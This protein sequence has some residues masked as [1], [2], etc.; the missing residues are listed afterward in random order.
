MHDWR[1]V[2]VEDDRVV[3]RLHC[4]FIAQVSGYSVAAVAASAAQAEEMVRVLRPDL[5]MLDIGLPGENG[6][7][8][9][10]R[11]RA[12]AED[13]EVI[14][15]TAA[16]ATATVHA[17]VQL[18]ALDY[19]VKPFD[20]DRLRKSLRL[21]E[22]RMSMLERAQ[23]AQRDVD[24]ICSEGPNVLRWLPRDVSGQRLDEIRG[25]LSG[26]RTGETAETVATQAGVARVTARRYLEYL[27]TIGQAT[28]EPVVDGPG[29]PRKT[30][31]LIYPGA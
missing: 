15:V 30:Y 11:L 5:L 13:V 27:V 29:R 22:R 16:T 9:L 31:Q 10:R 14:A 4:R 7:V 19:L 20:Q 6:I 23:L 2:V 21:F 3:A 24:R 8:L 17:A 28:M 18:G 26:A 25:I 12:A 1:V